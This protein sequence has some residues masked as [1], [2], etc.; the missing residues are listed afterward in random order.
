[1]KMLKTLL[2]S[3]LILFST[4][5]FSQEL[6]ENYQSIL[7]DFITYFSTIRTGNSVSKGKTSIRVINENKIILVVK[8]KGQ[9]KNLTFERKSDEENEKQWK[10]MNTLTSDM[11]IKYNDYVTETLN[12][13]HE[14]AKQK[15]ME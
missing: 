10:S 1:M 14:L 6:P 13:M 2:L 11:I 4:K 7:N 5:G 15:S 12:E 9:I 8:H 3:G